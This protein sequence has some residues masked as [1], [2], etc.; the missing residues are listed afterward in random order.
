MNGYKS[1]P[2]SIS[3]TCSSLIS[4]KNMGSSIKVLFPLASAA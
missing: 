3:L 4:R 1:L 2:G